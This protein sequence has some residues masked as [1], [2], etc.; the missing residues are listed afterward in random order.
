MVTVKPNCCSFSMS[1][2][3]AITLRARVIDAFVDASLRLRMVGG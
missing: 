2:E 3:N 1:G